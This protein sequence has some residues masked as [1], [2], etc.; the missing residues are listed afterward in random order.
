MLAFDVPE[1][2]N[3]PELDRLPPKLSMSAWHAEGAII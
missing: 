2:V 1:Y 3:V